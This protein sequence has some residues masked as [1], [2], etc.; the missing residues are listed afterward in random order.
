MRSF[1]RETVNCQII[2]QCIFSRLQNGIQYTMSWRWIIAIFLF[3]VWCLVI[4]FD[5]IESNQYPFKD[6]VLSSKC[7]EIC[8]H[9]LIKLHD[10]LIPIS[11]RDQRNELMTRRSSRERRKVNLFLLWLNRS[12]N[13]FSGNFHTL[14]ALTSFSAARF[15]A[16]LLSGPLYWMMN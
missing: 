6:L 9:N 12:E 14:K 2:I 16:R 10:P 15:V 7:E 5:E 4:F 13:I 8:I 1:Y 3:L 11:K